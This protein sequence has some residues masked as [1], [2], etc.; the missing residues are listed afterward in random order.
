MD[1]RATNSDEASLGELT[2]NSF[3]LLFFSN[4]SYRDFGFDMC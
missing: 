4:N 1:G 2:P 3:P